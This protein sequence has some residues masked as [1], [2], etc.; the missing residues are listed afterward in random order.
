MDS[1]RNDGA[2]TVVFSDDG[3]PPDSAAPAA[4]RRRWPWV[5]AIGAVAAAA[6]TAG[7]LVA[8]NLAP[9]PAGGA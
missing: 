7:V 3:M 4:T 1:S 6:A 2:G 8:G 5:V 9:T